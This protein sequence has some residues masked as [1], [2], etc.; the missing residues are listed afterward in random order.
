MHAFSIDIVEATV[1]AIGQ[2]GQ[3]VH[4]AAIM[5]G[6][7]VVGDFVGQ[8]PITVGLSPHDDVERF[9]AEG[10]IQRGQAVGQANI[11]TAVVVE[12]VGDDVR[13]V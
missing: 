9:F 7:E 2:S 5:F 3:S 10:G 4:I 6:A 8:N 11:G 1:G 12:D 13:A